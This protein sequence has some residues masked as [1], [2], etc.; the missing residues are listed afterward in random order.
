MLLI[1]GGTSALVAAIICSFGARPKALPYEPLRTPSAE[2]R[3]R[4][5]GAATLNAR[6]GDRRRIAAPVNGHRSPPS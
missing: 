4:I 2:I 5:D 3:E 6:N 1:V